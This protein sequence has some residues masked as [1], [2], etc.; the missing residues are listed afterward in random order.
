[1]PRDGSATK[2]KILEAAEGLV[3]DHGFGA[4]SIDQIL[5]KTSITKGAFFYHFKSKAELA[6]A[7]INRYVERD[8]ALLYD[9][10]QRAENLSRDP[11]QQVLIFVGLLEELF[12]SF[13]E[14]MAGC[15][16]AS[17]I[18]Q[19]EE[20]DISTKD[21]ITK[22][23]DEWH[24]VL[25]KKMSAVLKQYPAKFETSAD[26]LVDNLLAAFEGGL[27]LSKL[28]NKPQVM[29]EQLRHYKNYLEL[30]FA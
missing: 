29:A 27:I 21:I 23:F 2:E 9:L 19:F 18:Y 5:E 1:M 7:L 25:N 20:F 26:T 11:L 4:T 10:T 14:P 16:V 8:N 12:R 22:G 24:T 13:D 28:V 30:L 17:F 3:L 15:L 6:R